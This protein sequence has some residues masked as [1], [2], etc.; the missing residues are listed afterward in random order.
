MAERIH[1][2]KTQQRQVVLE[3]LK[4]LASHPTATELYEV[5]RRRLPRI[6]LGTIYRNL[7]LLVQMGLVRKVEA[8]G[9]EA[10]FDAELGHH[11]HVCC[12]RCGRIDDAEDLPDDVVPHTIKRLGGYVILGY[13]LGFEGICP[14]C[15]T[16]W[17][18]CADG[19]N[20]SQR[21][22]TD[23]RASGRTDVASPEQRPDNFFQN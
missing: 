7:D 3:E 16:D 21:R 2:R 17:M 19:A 6:S 22:S 4:K 11:Y 10:R 15:R 5:A 12:V 9:S 20:P 1:R 18:D 14:A 23:P 8:H 13:N